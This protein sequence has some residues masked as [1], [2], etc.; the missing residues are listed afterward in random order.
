MKLFRLILCLALTAGCTLLLTSGCS[1]DIAGATTETTNGISG[2]ILNNDD[3]PAPNTVV[4]LLPD[5]FNPVTDSSSGFTDTTDAVGSY[6]FSHVGAGRYVVLARNRAAVTSFLVRNVT[7][8]DDSLTNIPVG[9]LDKSGSIAA[10]FSTSG[11]AAGGYVY[12]PGTDISSPVR[13]DGL[14]LLPGIPKGTFTSVI[15]TMVDLKRLNVL[16]SEITVAAGSTVIIEQP[17]LK[18]SRRIGF[19]TTSAGADVAGDVTNFPVLIRLNS[20]NFDFTQTRADGGDLVFTG[21]DKSVLPAEIERWDAAAGRAEIWVKVDTVFGNDSDQSITMY[22]GND[23][24]GPKVKSG[25]VFDTTAGFQG[26]W[27]L[28][29]AALDSIHDATANRYC[30]VSPDSARPVVAD[31]VIGNCRKFDGTAN[32]ITMPGTSEGKLNFPESGQYTVSAWVSLDTSDGVSHCIVSKGY[33]QYYIRATY[34]STNILNT[35]PFWEFVEF[36]ETVKWQTSNSAAV[37]KQWVLL[38]GVRQGNRQLLYCNGVLVDSTIDV[39]QNAV[40]RSTVNDLTIGAFAKP[41]TVPMVEGYCYFKGEID[42]VRI[43]SSAQSP[44]WVRLCYMNQRPDD[45]LVVFR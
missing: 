32:Y 9:T 6:R 12:I 28:A 17:L 15:L 38:V 1:K 43:I 24:V 22:W 5:D 16:R 19:N 35:T 31:G 44:D 14:T 33:E 18:Y 25:M 27:H 13:T 36:S 10:D 20:G 7:V 42:E 21:R 3:S 39:W 45:R 29:D 34:I 30:G 37:S 26:V 11:I 2:V 8:T 4:K 41:V 40:S 23:E